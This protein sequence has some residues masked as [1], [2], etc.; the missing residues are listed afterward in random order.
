MSFSHPGDLVRANLLHDSSDHPMSGGIELDKCTGATFDHNVVFRNPIW[1]LVIFRR[2]DLV[3]NRWLHNLFIPRRQPGI[4]SSR[5]KKLFNGIQGWELQPGTEDFAP[6]EEFIEAMQGYAGLEPAYRKAILGADPN[7]CELYVLEDGI[8]WQFD[9]PE[10][11]WGVVYRIDVQVEKGV[12]PRLVEGK[13]V[14]VKL[15]KLDPAAAYTLNAYAGPVRRTPTDSSSQE[16]GGDFRWGPLF[17]MVHEI[18]PA[19]DLGLPESA[20]GREL[21]ENGVT[22]KDGSVAV[23]VTYRKAKP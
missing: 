18:E 21:M 16:E 4:S 9:F 15:T 7:P 3:E 13:A 22:L 8:T 14:A 20:T 5:A 12:L 11:G 19:S 23:W 10:Q 2:V 17:P 6:P 1:T